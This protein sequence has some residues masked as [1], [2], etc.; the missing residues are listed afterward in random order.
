[1]QWWNDFVTWFSSDAGQQVLVSAVIPFVAIVV[2]GLI[3]ALIGRSTV[4][5]IVGQRDY[6]T[7]AGAVAA[8]ISV[9]QD[10][11]RWHGETPT[12]REH[13]ERLAREADT[14][15]R[16]LP[17][18]AS[19]LAADWAAHQ[20]RDM[21]INSV[22]FSFQAEQTLGEYRDRLIL[23]L[24]KPNKARKLFAADLERWRYEDQSVD[25]LVTEQQKWAEAQFTANTDQNVE[26]APDVVVPDVIIPASVTAPAAAT[27]VGQPIV[28]APDEAAGEP[29]EAASTLTP[30]DVFVNR[31]A[32]P[33]ASTTTTGLDTD[34]DTDDV[35]VAE[36]V[37]E[38]ANDQSR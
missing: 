30:S 23:W 25:P 29:A 28:S 24:R 31:Y 34:T 36:I 20:L 37:D 4:K 5:R 38:P 6:E 21:R 2:A 11:V 26:H 18:P 27:M 13:S 16:L 12:S 10:A 22:S 7:R 32:S 17:I 9:G 33:L 1:M 3:A 8:L 35:E 14:Q 15:V 19:D